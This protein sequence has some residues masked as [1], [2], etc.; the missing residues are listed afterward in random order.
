VSGL[1]KLRKDS[2]ECKNVLH[3]VNTEQERNTQAELEVSDEHSPHQPQC[4]D[5]VQDDTE[6]RGNAN[7]KKVEQVV[8]ERVSS[9]DLPDEDVN[10]PGNG[11]SNTKQEQ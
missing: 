9:V 10:Q 1:S 2:E 11:D 3:G 6:E 7:V 4:P 5:A 8:E